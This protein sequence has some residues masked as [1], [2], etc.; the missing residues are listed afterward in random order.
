M[1]AGS[2][3]VWQPSLAHGSTPNRSDRPRAAQLLTFR[4]T[5]KFERAT[6]ELRAQCLR[7]QLDALPAFEPTPL[8]RRLFGLD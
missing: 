2:L 8:G 3:L 7:A 4:R 6:L 5:S 1:R